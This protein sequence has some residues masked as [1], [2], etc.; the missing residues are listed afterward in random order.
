MEDIFKLQDWKGFGININGEYLTHL[1]FADD[2]VLMAETLED[3]NTMLEDLSNASQRVGLKMN[4]DKT[5]VMSNAHVVPA[6][7]K[8]GNVTLEVV[9]HI[10][11]DRQSS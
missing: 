9:D 6:P 5:K 4:M 11:W 2:I 10:T 1:R 7:V 3:L 8:V